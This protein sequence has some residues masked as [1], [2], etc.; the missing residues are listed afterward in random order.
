MK[1]SKQIFS[2]LLAGLLT[3]TAL[4]SCGGNGE[5][6]EEKD[7]GKAKLIIWDWDEPHLNYMPGYY[8]E[9]NPDANVEFETLLVSTDDY[10][11]KF[12]SSVAAE[13]DV[14]DV[15]LSEL[16][17]RGRLFDMG[18]LEDLSQEPYNVQ[19]DDMF[20]FAWDFGSGP[21]GELLGVEQQIC[22]TGF[23][24]RRDLAKEYLGTDD[25][26]EL[27][28]MMPDWDAFIELGKQVKE[29][30]GGSV[31]IY[32][33]VSAMIGLLRYQNPFAYIEGDTINLTERYKDLLELAT[34]MNQ[35]GVLGN[36]TGP[37]L[38]SGYAEGKFIFVECAPWATKF[39]I[40]TNDPE[41]SGRWGLTK[42]PGGGATNGGTS[43]SIYSGSKYKEE[44]W[45]YIKFAYCDGPGVE[46]AYK[47]FNYMTGFK[48]PYE[49]EDSYFFTQTGPYD[50]FFGGQNLT[51][52][53]INEISLSITGQPQTKNEA[54]VTT[55]LNAVT[56]QLVDD[57]SITAD[58]ALELL[59]NELQT[60][61]PNATIN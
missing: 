54:S 39:N 57:P 11:Q 15:V 28:A 45:D 8:L 60:L 33:S 7:S 36:L 44:A 58:E 34:K 21:N 56:P 51:D 40:S 27:A 13:T 48:A 37:A 47:K 18:V 19:K 35:S 2:V 42:I 55:A 26:D 16:G 46:E 31:V 32:P 5:E 53:F 29:K 52:Y 22:P 14:P 20:Q 43:V 1:K 17:Y 41:G 50:E 9:Q 12:Q 4:A 3:M 61:V 24:Y 38:N 6:A 23:A 49:S 30:S 10:M 25:P 59:K